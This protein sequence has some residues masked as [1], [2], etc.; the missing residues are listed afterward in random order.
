MPQLNFF[1]FFFFFA[2]IPFSL[3]TFQNAASAWIHSL[4]GTRTLPAKW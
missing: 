2:N 3:C 1:S 4:C